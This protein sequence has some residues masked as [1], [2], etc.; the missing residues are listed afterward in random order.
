MAKYY[1]GIGSRA[2]PIEEC[3][4]LERV[5]RFLKE[6]GYTL[7][8]GGAEGSDKAFEHGAGPF[9][10]VIYR[11]LDAT[12]RSIQEASL[13]HPAWDKCDVPARKLHGRNVQIILGRDLNEPVDFVIFWSRNPTRGGTSLGVNL[14]EQYG[15]SVFN[16]AKADKEKEFY[17]YFERI[18]GCV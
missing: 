4:K 2:I 5:A 1:A 6:K 7:R 17:D 10:S 14:A 18:W 3:E 13:I 9:G 12:D 11:P 8:S 16:F 15:I